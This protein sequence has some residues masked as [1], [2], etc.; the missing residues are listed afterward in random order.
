MFYSESLST[1]YHSGALRGQQWRGQWASSKFKNKFKKS[2]WREGR[3]VQTHS[4]WTRLKKQKKNKN[5][6]VELSLFSTAWQNLQHD[7]WFSA[8]LHESNT[9]TI[10]LCSGAPNSPTLEEGF[11]AC[12]LKSIREKLGGG[13][14][15]LFPRLYGQLFSAFNDKSV[16][17]A[18][19]VERHQLLVNRQTTAVRVFRFIYFASRN[20]KNTFCAFAF[21]SVLDALT[22]NDWSALSFSLVF[23]SRLFP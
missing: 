18:F 21:P 10:N 23:K 1:V 11:C 17:T 9:T 2:K 4:F 5:K 15:Q 13:G 3:V 7:W 6:T 12:L 22:L 14:N 19:N 20:R 8:N 16:S